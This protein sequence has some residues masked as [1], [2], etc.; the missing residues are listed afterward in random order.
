MIMNYEWSFFFSSVKCRLLK[1][2]KK[3]TVTM[4]LSGATPRSFDPDEPPLTPHPSGIDYEARERALAAREATFRKTEA[5]HE[6]LVNDIAIKL[7]ADDAAAEARATEYDAKLTELNVTHAAN[8]AELKAATP[9]HIGAV[10]SSRNVVA[11]AA[12]ENA[13]ALLLLPP[14]THTEPS[15]RPTSSRLTIQ[16]AVHTSSMSSSRGRMPTGSEASSSQ[17]PKSKLPKMLAAQTST[18][19]AAAKPPGSHAQVSARPASARLAMQA[20]V[21]SP[22]A[23]SMRRHYPSLAVLDEGGAAVPLTSSAALCEQLSELATQ[24]AALCSDRAA[25][26]ERA[27]AYAQ[28]ELA[29]TE[30]VAVHEQNVALHARVSSTHADAVASHDVTLLMHEMEVESLS[31]QLREVEAAKDD[32]VRHDARAEDDAAAHE[33]RVAAHCLVVTEHTEAAAAHEVSVLMHKLEVESLTAQLSQIEAAKVDLVQ[34]DCR[35]EEIATAHD[36]RVE[37]LRGAETSHDERIAVHEAN[38]AALALVNHEL[39]ERAAAHTL[40]VAAHL[41]AVAAHSELAAEARV[42]KLEAAK[43]D[44]AKHEAAKAMILEMDAQCTSLADEAGA[45]AAELSAERK[46]RGVREKEQASLLLELDAQCSE[47]GAEADKLKQQLTEAKAA[48]QQLLVTPQPPESAT[49][50]EVASFRLS[51]IDGAAFDPEVPPSTPHSSGVDYEARERAFAARETA[52]AKTEADHEAL[53]SVIATELAADNA[54]AEARAAE[55]EAKLTKLKATQSM[56][57]ANLSTRNAA[58]VEKDAQCTALAEQVSGLTSEL[59]AAQSERPQRGAED[60]ARSSSV[61]KTGLGTSRKQEL[62]QEFKIHSENEQMLTMKVQCSALASDAEMLKS[63]LAAARL[64]HS[65]Q[66]DEIARL[67]L[68][69]THAHVRRARAKVDSD[70][71]EAEPSKLSL[72]LEKSNIGQTFPDAAVATCGLQDAVLAAQRDL[73]ACWH[74]DMKALYTA[75]QHLW[76]G[77]DPTSPLSCAAHHSS[78]VAADPCA[79]IFAAIAQGPDEALAALAVASD[80]LKGDKSVVMAAVA[81]TGHALDWATNEL[82]ADKEVVLAAVQENSYAVRYAA[83]SLQHD[84][85]ILRAAQW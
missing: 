30:R 38:V 35:A 68:A 2:R 45:L 37:A 58:F 20:A 56:H 15:Q 21:H 44:R 19:P 16:A 28:S 80:A 52:F 57:V 8:L 67:N 84:A 48:A 34:H 11:S 6:A 55:Y 29:H 46:A 5:A 39:E 78:P 33:Q 79:L 22:K 72:N 69:S 23:E 64:E 32:L 75:Y 59:A 62:Q 81:Q 25:L 53:V 85:D 26:G 40:T 36:A 47:L 3:Y 4:R 14:G 10:A 70:A 74:A 50:I 82:K 43:E 66:N 27:A 49:A 24:R 1:K 7:A 12:A 83:A 63:E 42:S 54:A 17:Q 61:L 77:A 76:S 9:A 60:H 41:E 18:L 71:L 51:M 73:E 13:M 31:K 65:R